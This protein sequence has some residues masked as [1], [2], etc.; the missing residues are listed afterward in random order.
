[1]KT[2]SRPDHLIEIHAG[3][4]L[5]PEDDQLQ[6]CQVWRWQ[7]ASRTSAPCTELQ[8]NLDDFFC[9]KKIKYLI[10]FI[11]YKP[12]GDAQP[13]LS[14]TF[15]DAPKNHISFTHQFFI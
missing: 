2:A 13:I 6:A 7:L 3:L 11:D 12:Y 9:L 15:P 10:W 8:L 1:M 14:F 5:T 4:Y